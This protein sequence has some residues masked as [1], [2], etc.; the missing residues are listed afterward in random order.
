[1]V[2]STSPRIYSATYSN[3]PVYE[4]QFGEDLKEHVMRRRGDDWI[5]ATH[6]L[7]AAGFDKPTRTRILE[8]EVQKEKHEKIQG[9]YGKYQG[10][11]VPLEQGKALAQRNHVYEKLRVIFE[12]TSGVESPPTA[13]RHTTAKPKASKRAS[14]QRYH[15][16]PA[17]TRN[18]ENEDESK[19]IQQDHQSIADDTTVASGMDIDESY[20]ILPQST[21]LR[22][23]KRSTITAHEQA[24]ILY[25]DELLDYFMLSSDL[26]G[27]TKPEPPLNFN[28]DWIID[29]EGHTAL[30][31][32]AAMGDVDVIRDLKRYG[33]NIGFQN[34][35]GE[36][37]LMRCVQFINC[38][39][40]KTMP[41]VVNEL[42]ET[43]D[44]PDFCNS[45]AL[46]HAAAVTVS[47]QKHSCARYYLD[48]I[49]NKIQE[50]Y[51]PQFAAQLINAQDIDG[52]TA[53]HI[54]VKHRARKCVRALI[55]RNAAINIRN[56]E[57]ITAEDEIRG[58]NDT[59]KIDFQATGSSSPFGIGIDIPFG[60]QTPEEPRKTLHHISEVAM[61]IQ[62]K[63]AP[64]L[65]ERILNLADSFDDEL[66]QK[67]TSEQEA[68]R[69]LNL[70]IV[71]SEGLEKQVTDLQKIKE[72]PET[73]ARC[74]DELHLIEKKFV[75]LVEYQQ[76][77]QLRNLCDR[78]RKEGE[79]IGFDGKESE[80]YDI[81]DRVM[82]SR[83]LDGLQKKRQVLVRSYIEARSMTG[84]SEK[85]EL[86][87]RALVKSLG[88]DV[89][90]VDEN[91]DALVE[92]L[93]DDQNCH[94]PE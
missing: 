94:P 76:M 32:A 69:I 91:L 25:S 39:E 26:V 38:Q 74:Q 9:G 35:R 3:I 57:G 27:R 13:P 34:A 16:T 66:K 50:V 42:I 2:K 54:A 90:L 19:V 4:F 80:E 81:S 8:R 75:S 17:T 12:Y 88:P 20:E 10:T 48:I 86:Y 43:V 41:E 49:L 6:I 7:K 67:D 28:P 22:K 45:T 62:N 1:M 51:E 55:G 65:M 14:L 83:I 85:S 56:N 63:V 44:I 15:N 92:Q 84:G 82:L 77:I 31:W 71:E 58:L 53:L 21:S 29:N 18:I 46:H 93:N 73:A 64:Q 23:R 72:S 78:E 11:W 47:Q 89:S 33:A 61:S 37:P 24:H 60:R 40:K 68:R 5:N 59:R 30:H 52:E 79:F 36:T 70:T 87:R